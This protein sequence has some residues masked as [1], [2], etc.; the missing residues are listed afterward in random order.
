MWRKGNP[1][2]LL[3]AMEI[4]TATMENSMVVS[5]KLKMKLPYKSKNTTWDIYLKE[6]KS[7]SWRDICTPM[8]IET[9]FTQAKIWKQSKYSHTHAEIVNHSSWEKK[10]ILPF[11]TT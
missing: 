6:M 5:K 11:V 2:V 3:V 4:G 10:E 9:L 7:L 1:C 8:V